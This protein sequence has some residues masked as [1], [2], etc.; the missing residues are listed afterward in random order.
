MKRPRWLP[1]DVE[2]LTKGTLCV[3]EGRGSRPFAFLYTRV[4]PTRGVL[5]VTLYGPKTRDGRSSDS[6]QYVTTAPEKVRILG[7]HA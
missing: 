2:T 3:V 7:D 6:M 4:S 5:E 1:A